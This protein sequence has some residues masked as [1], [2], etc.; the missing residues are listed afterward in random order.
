MR[1]SRAPG[2]EWGTDLSFS[3]VYYVREMDFTGDAA[4]SNQVQNGDQLWEVIPIV[5][6][7][8]EGGTNQ[9]TVNGSSL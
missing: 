1:L 8:G 2:I 9:F 5:V 4:M 6:A 7:S 3:F